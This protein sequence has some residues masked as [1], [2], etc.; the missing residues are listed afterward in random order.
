MR[1]LLQSISFVSLASVLSGLLRPREFAVCRQ[2][3]CLGW[4]VSR[5]RAVSTT[6]NFEKSRLPLAIAIFSRGD[7]GR[8][9]ISGVCRE[10]PRP[11]GGAASGGMNQFKLSCQ[12]SAIPTA[13]LM[14]LQRPALHCRQLAL[15]AVRDQVRRVIAFQRQQH[16]NGTPKGHSA[17][18]QT[19]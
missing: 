16:H 3:L 14:Q 7:R 19:T 10:F 15:E 13:Q 11:T 5:T 6:R 4:P 12:S 9:A 2:H 1:V 17:I 18:P 8:D